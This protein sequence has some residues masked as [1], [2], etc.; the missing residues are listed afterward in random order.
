MDK[1]AELEIKGS[2]DITLQT[3]Q[4][5]SGR[6]LKI[7]LGTFSVEKRPLANAPSLIGIKFAFFIG[8]G[9]TLCLKHLCEQLD[10]T[11]KNYIKHKVINISLGFTEDGRQM[12]PGMFCQSA[13][14]FSGE[15]T[16]T[17]IVLE[18]VS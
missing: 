12:S 15:L 5:K 13:A 16:V 17:P 9:R 2:E 11:L 10:M 4:S 18:Q 1:I 6:V 14:I 3:R 8:E 7:Y